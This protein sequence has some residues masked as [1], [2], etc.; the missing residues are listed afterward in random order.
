M[1]KILKGGFL[2]SLIALTI[3]GCK[4]PWQDHLTETDGIPDSDILELLQNTSE[5]SDFTGLLLETGWVEELE[6]SKSY[7]VWAPDNNAMNEIDAADLSDSASLAMFINNHITF[8]AYSY[9]SPVR[10]QIIK[11]FS[12]KNIH[13]DNENGKVDD[14]NLLEPYD[15]VASNGI[16]HM[17]DKAL[18]PKPN[19]WD[20]VET[21]DLAPKHVDYLKSLSG[22]VFDPSIATITGVDPVTGRPVY[23]T[24]SGM[25][26]SNQLLAEVRDLKHEDTLS[27]IILI[28]DD[29]FDSEFAKYRKYFKVAD[30]LAS[31]ELTRWLICRDLVFSGLTNMQDM[32]DTLTS[33]YGIKIPFNASSVHK[34][35]EASNGIVYVMSSCDVLLKEKIP[36]SVTEG[37]DTNMVIFTSVSGQ[38]GFTREK[39]LASGGYDF[40]LDNHGASPGNIKYHMG[41][42]VAGYY[43]FYWVAI[44]DFN[45]AIRGSGG[46]DTLWQFLEFV[47]LEGMAGSE[48]IW[49]DPS[50]ISP[51]LIPV[52]D[53]TYETAREV[54]L[55][56]RFFN[57][58]QDVWL[59]VT[60][61]G[62]NTTLSLDYLKAVPL[63]E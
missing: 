36:P 13:I 43:D 11:T 8:G 26:W 12:G 56:Q 53:S 46:G 33:L 17:I 35:Y 60:G 44:D 3:W 42:L 32:P 1:N 45:G 27:T 2:L 50:P 58:Y 39:D 51:D 22:M 23:D 40:V 20:F 55:G 19:V 38:T 30:S 47:R 10:E 24:L 15:Q 61:A 48:M 18:K 6:S 57:T 9:Y 63:Y 16:L 52:I 37:E 34:I 28:D 29:V 49:S 59:Q 7:T 31:D 14:A 5:L 25:I 41:N 4:D 62:R 54:Y 21:T